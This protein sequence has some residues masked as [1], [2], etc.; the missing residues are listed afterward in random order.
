ME[1]ETSSASDAA[2]DTSAANDIGGFEASVSAEAPSSG[3]SPG[4]LD[5]TAGGAGLGEGTSGGGNE[6]SATAGLAAPAMTF[7]SD[8]SDLGK[9][10]AVATGAVIS[11]MNLASG[12]LALGSVQAVG[13]VFAGVAANQSFANVGHDVATAAVVGAAVSQQAIGMQ[14]LLAI[15]FQPF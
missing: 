3:D 15:G 12:K 7:A 6:I 4:S 10:G 5:T 8:V 1:N 9:I 2:A 11:A 14:Q 13:V